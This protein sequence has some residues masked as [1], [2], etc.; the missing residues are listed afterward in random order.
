MSARGRGAEV[1]A[2][3]FYETPAWCVRR[4]LESIPEPSGKRW[5]EPAVG[6]GA[7]VRACNGYIG[8][9]GHLINNGIPQFDGFDLVERPGAAACCRF[10]E[11]DIR[12]AVASPQTIA[13][14]ITPNRYDLSITNPP[15][16]LALYFAEYGIRNAD[17]TA[18]LLRL[19]WLECGASEATL[20]RARF[21]AAH[22]PDV[23][24]LPN[25][26]SFTGRGTDA[27]AYAWFCW[28]FGFRSGT[29]R[30]LATTPKEERR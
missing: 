12:K 24:I 16:S 18:L 22:A 28:G 21:L 11:R 13:E 1:T 20:K 5:V 29:W 4:L 3:E 30:M 14:A 26:P 7:I 15:F 9:L 8:G 10:F 2:D 23:R 27:C 19:N 25:R 17:R 6:S